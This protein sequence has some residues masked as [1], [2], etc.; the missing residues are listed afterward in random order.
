MGA[1]TATGARPNTH[2]YIFPPFCRSVKEKQKAGLAAQAAAKAAQAA[3]KA[4]A[5]EDQGGAGAGA[6]DGEAG[7]EDY[8]R[9]P[10]AK[11]EVCERTALLVVLALMSFSDGDACGAQRLVVC[12]VTRPPDTMFPTR[13]THA[14]THPAQQDRAA[15]SKGLPVKTLDGQLVF[16]EA[17]GSARAKKLRAAAQQVAAS[18]GGILIEDTLEDEERQR[19]E[20]ARAARAAAEAA[21]AA[22]LRERREQEAT[23]AAAAR[24]AAAGAPPALAAL[25]AAR[26][27]DDRRDVARRQMAATAQQ[28][29][30]HP[31]RYASM[32]L[33]V[34]NEMARDADPQISRLAMLSALAVF[35]DILPEYKIRPPTEAEL[36]VKASKEVQQLRDHEAA[37]LKHYQSY[38]K[39]LLAAAD[40]APPRGGGK[41]GMGGSKSGGG[42]GAKAAESAL[43]TARVAVRCLAGLLVARPGFNY[44]SD[45]LQ[46][47]GWEG[48]QDGRGGGRD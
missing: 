22:A 29:L 7:V 47:R 12:C 11:E 1:P 48:W 31:E 36:A 34:L 37:L 21:K 3:A 26:T 28:L 13:Q 33:R 30:S 4:A 35:R 18:V 39:L 14:H 27:K 17:Q 23:A 42:G 10:R 6:D 38:L 15:P 32:G 44:S 43:A 25:A 40:E 5:G 46:V 45:I 16:A 9:R 20:A 19:K 8:E 41:G 24:A 2:I